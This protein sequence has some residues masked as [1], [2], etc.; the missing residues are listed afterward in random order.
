MRCVVGG[1][2]VYSIFS[3]GLDQGL[4][5]FPSLDGRIALDER[6]LGLIPGLIEEQV[7][8][9]D[10]HGDVLVFYGSC[11]EEFE[12]PR[13]GEMKHMV[14]WSHACA[15]VPRPDDE[16]LKQ[17]SSE[18]MRACSEKGILSP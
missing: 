15:R 13:G 4:L 3:E 12:F 16:D 6:T 2:D 8:S 14:N 9:A 10:L 11:F 17:A 1:D 5:I 18:R 7:M